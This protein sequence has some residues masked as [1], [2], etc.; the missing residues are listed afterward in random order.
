MSADVFAALRTQP[1]IGRV[2][3]EDEDKLG[4]E[5]VAVI[6]HALWRDRFGGDAGIV[7]KAI[8][9]NGKPYSILG[10][11]PAGFEFPNKVDLWLP[12]GP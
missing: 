8:S 7:N 5:P 9:L 11:M 10:V 3:R 4:A 2:F 1:E 6:S 12:V